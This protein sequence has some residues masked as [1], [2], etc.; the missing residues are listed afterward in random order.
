MAVTMNE[1]KVI[2]KDGRQIR[3]VPI[4]KFRLSF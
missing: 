1:E 2:E 4:S 3:L